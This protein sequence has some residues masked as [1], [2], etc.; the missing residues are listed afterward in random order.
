MIDFLR[1]KLIYFLFSLFLIFLG[2]FFI[3]RWGFN[4]SIDFIGG[5]NIEFRSDKKNFSEE[6]I[7]SVLKKNKINFK[8]LELNEDKIVLKTTS[9]S[10]KEIDN[11]IK[12]I[13][14]DLKIKIKII[15]SETI[16]PG[17]SKETTRKTIIAFLLALIGILFY[18]SFAFRGFN[19][20]I[21]G[22]LAMIHDFLILVGIYSIFSY[23][24]QAEFDLMFVTAILTTMSFSIHDTIVIF[25]KIRE[26]LKETEKL[27]NID[28]FA[29]QALNET[30]I[31][32]LN[33]SLTIIFMLLS[34]I[35]FGGS[36][37]RFFAL[38][39]L[40]GIITGTY[41]SPFIATPILVWLEKR[42]N[43]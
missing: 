10:P 2:L 1:Y 33:N 4:Y 34:I 24:F 20:A 5:T 14:K 19:Y 6:K 41:S 29:N 36:T 9:L 22:I 17:L 7:K 32:S 31:R 35:I 16:G 30:M 23:F 43:K 27:K 21:A 18:M 42:K 8:Y 37:V 12:E 26:Y 40:V 39:L 15:K 28:F 3:F 38:A 11:L 13:E 25:D